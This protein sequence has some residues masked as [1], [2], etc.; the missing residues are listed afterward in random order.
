[1]DRRLVAWLRHL[2]RGDG[3]HVSTHVPLSEEDA[4]GVSS[5]REGFEQGRRREASG[6]QVSHGEAQ[7]R[8]ER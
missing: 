6:A 8:H 7:G 1:M 3:A 4:Q 2:G 5:R